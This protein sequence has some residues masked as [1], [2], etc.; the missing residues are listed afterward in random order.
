MSFFGA[1]LDLVVLWGVKYNA[2]NWAT[3]FWTCKS[4]PGLGW[5][6][7]GASSHGKFTCFELFLYATFHC[8]LFNIYNEIIYDIYTVNN[9]PDALIF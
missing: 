1:I 5:F 2:S 3:L 4:F 7:H 8:V 9:L 6:L